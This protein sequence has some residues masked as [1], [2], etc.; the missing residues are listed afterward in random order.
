MVGVLVLFRHVL[1]ILV[2]SHNCVGFRVLWMRRI[3]LKFEGGGCCEYEVNHVLDLS[4][5]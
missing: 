4:V 5:G 3:H 1:G 2:V